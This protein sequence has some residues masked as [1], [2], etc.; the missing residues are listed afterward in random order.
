MFTWKGQNEN[1]SYFVYGVLN[2]FNEINELCS[3]FIF[4]TLLSNSSVDWETN[5]CKHFILTFKLNLGR[6]HSD[7]A[8]FFKIKAIYG[9]Y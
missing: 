7:F 2:V 1:T 9:I 5:Y 3:S 8:G 6:A 4:M